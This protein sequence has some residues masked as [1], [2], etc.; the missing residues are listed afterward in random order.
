MCLAGY[1]GHWSRRTN[2]PKCEHERLEIGLKPI[3]PSELGSS[4]VDYLQCPGDLIH[5]AEDNDLETVAHD[6]DELGV[7]RML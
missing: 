5:V 2:R 6:I 3:I 4:F 1:E 7:S